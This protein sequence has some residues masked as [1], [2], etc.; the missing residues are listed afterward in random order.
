MR[1]ERASEVANPFIT[2]GW[3]A[4]YLNQAEASEVL[5]AD[6]AAQTPERNLR[7]PNRTTLSPHYCRRRL[8]VQPV[9]LLRL[10]AKPDVQP[11]E[12]LLPI[13][14]CSPVAEVLL[15]RAPAV[16]VRPDVAAHLAV[17]ALP[18]AG[19]CDGLQPLVTVVCSS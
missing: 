6:R 16:H 3:R 15:K 9:T 2:A 11:I 7:T 1:F 14:T 5:L 18:N 12:R 13:L 10:F 17:S 19:N 4:R 8:A